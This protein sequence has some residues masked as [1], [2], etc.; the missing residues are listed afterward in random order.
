MRLRCSKRKEKALVYIMCL[1]YFLEKM[2]INYYFIIILYKVKTI[3]NHKFDGFGSVIVMQNMAW[4]S[5]T[6]VSLS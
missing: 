4:F 2:G 6:V 1:R 3:N 5:I